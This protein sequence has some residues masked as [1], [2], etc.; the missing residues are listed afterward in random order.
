M[1]QVVNAFTASSR[2][3]CCSVCGLNAGKTNPNDPRSADRP[4]IVLADID[5]EGTF[6]ICMSCAVE[7]GQTAGLVTP[8]AYDAVVEAL[9]TAVAQAEVAAGVVAASQLALAAV[10]V[11]REVAGSE[12]SE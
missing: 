4:V 10:G 11:F 3:P 8:D 1:I 9:D 12:D 7:V 2:V 6:D 5:Q